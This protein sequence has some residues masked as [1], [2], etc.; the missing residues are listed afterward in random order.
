MVGTPATNDALVWNGA[1]WAPSSL[2]FNYSFIGMVDGPMTF[3]GA[4]NH[5]LVVDPTE[6]KS[7]PAHRS[8]SGPILGGPPNPWEARGT[9]RVHIATNEFR[10]AANT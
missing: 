9:L 7:A 6:T 1:T 10:G 5:F 3:D 4:A 2:V 8:T